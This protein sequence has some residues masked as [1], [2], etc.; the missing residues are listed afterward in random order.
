MTPIVALSTLV[1]NF[2]Q[3]HLPVERHASRNTIIAYRDSLKLFLQFAAETTGT[4]VDQLGMDA[5]EPDMVRGFLVWLDQTRHCNARTRNHRLAALKSFARYVA[6]AA[7]E[8]LDRCRRVRE[9][10]P[11]RFEHPPIHYLDDDEVRALFQT[12]DAG[13]AP[14]DCALL[15][16]LYNTGARVQEIVSL[17]LA[18]LRLDSVALVTLEGK[19]RKQR[20]CPLWPRTVDALRAWIQNRGDHDGPLF[21]NRLGQRLT[22]SGLAWILRKYASRLD[23]SPR[24]TSKVTPHVIRHTTAMHLLEA[25]VDIT[26]IAAWLGHA[27][28]ATTHGYVEITL[29]MK[30]KVIA[31]DIAL[32]KLS[33]AS[34]PRGDLLSW[35]TR[36]CRSHGYVQHPTSLAANPGNIASDLRITARSP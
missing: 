17:D 32:P 9:L 34:F 26:T 33:S 11:A 35:L 6:S 27:Q 10:V 5:L 24:H 28:L 3:T 22:R 36:L 12:I 7:P 16:L 30:Q 23:S 29:R 2:F 14:R 31:S 8:H 1:Q 19:G 18:D 4:D 15:L 25:D 13:S 21:L 20:T